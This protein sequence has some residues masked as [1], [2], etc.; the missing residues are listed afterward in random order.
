MIERQLFRP[1]VRWTVRPAVGW[2]AIPRRA[3]QPIG[4]V[5]QVGRVE[6]RP[7]QQN[8]QGVDV[9]GAGRASHQRRLHRRRA[10]AHEGVVHRFAGRRQPVDDKGGQLRLETG[11]TADLVGRMG[12]SQAGCPEPVDE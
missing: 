6:A 7:G 11:A 3:L 10:A 8:G 9:G 1:T 2:G 5:G 4:D 12:L